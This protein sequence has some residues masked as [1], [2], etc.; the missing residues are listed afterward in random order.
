MQQV[1]SPTVEAPQLEPNEARK[2]HK[3]AYCYICEADGEKLAVLFTIFYKH[4][5]KRCKYVVSRVT[6]V[7]RP[8]D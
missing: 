2:K 4:S 6:Q 3:F 8:T 7:R 1:S 5:K